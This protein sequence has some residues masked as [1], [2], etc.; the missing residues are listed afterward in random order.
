MPFSQ[1]NLHLLVIEDNPGDF[2]L[3]EEYLREEMKSITIQHATTLKGAR[4]IIS[5]R[6]KID[7]VLLDLSLPDAKGEHL[8]NDVLTL[9]GDTPLIVLTGYADRGFSIKTLSLGVSDYLLK[10]DLTAP[11]LFKSI[12]YSIER[13]R[14]SNEL[15]GSEEKYRSL[16]RSS[17][18]PM[19]VYDPA[20][21]FFLDVNEAACRHYGYSKEEFLAMT[22]KDIRP[23]EDIKRIEKIVQANKG[24]TNYFEEVFLHLKK[25]GEL[26]HANIQSNAITFS[27]KTARLVVS[28]DVTEKI[29]AENALKLSEQR[30]KSLVQDGSD[31]IYILGKDGGY[32]YVSPTSESILGMRPEEFISKNFFDFI[33]ENDRQRI[34]NQFTLL[35]SRKRIHILPFRFKCPNNTYR[36]VETIVTNMMEDPSINGMVANSR[37]VS[38]RYVYEEKLRKQEALFRAIIEKGSDMKTLITPEGKI[39]FGT[40]SITRILGYSEEEY[41]GKNEREIVH[42]DD[43]E[44]LFKRINRSISGEKS[45]GNLELRVRAKSGEYRWCEKTITNLLNDPDVNAIVCDFWDITDK[46]KADLQIKESNDRYDL[47]SKATSDA[48]WDYTFSTNKTYIAGTGYKHLFGYDIVN[49]YTEDLFWEEHLHPEDK[50]EVIEKLR[51]FIADTSLTQCA[52]EYRFMKA[53]GNYAYVNDRLFI[54]RENGIPMRLIGAINDITR[55]KEEEQHLKLLESVI[56]NASDS[57]MITEAV[58]SEKRVPKI[59]YVNEAFTNMSGYSNTEIVGKTP[60]LLLGPRSGRKEILR[61]NK[62]FRNHESCNVEMIN[63][64]KN[65]LPYWVE[66]DVAHVVGITGNVSH[67]IAIQRDITSRKIQEQE[68]EKLIFELIQNNKDLRQFSYITS[69]NLR[70]PIASLLGLTNL[71]DNYR[72]E[73]PVLGKILEGVK[74]A[75]SRFDETITDLTAVLNIKDRPSIPKEELNLK[76]SFEKIMQQ[77]EVFIKENKV[78]V[79]NDF[80]QAPTIHFNKAYLDSILLNLLTNAIKYRSPLRELRIDVSTEQTEEEVLLKFKDNGLGFDMELHKGKLF[81]LYQRFHEHVE[82]KGMGL[83]LVKSQM[84]ALNGNIEVSSDTASGTLFTLKFKKTA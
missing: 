20:T 57:V 48:I 2:V 50:N 84:E 27:G 9:T 82:G 33:H 72:I 13:K 15:K 18:L 55:R 79:K 14:I 54:I 34:I 68:R 52:Y 17:P 51:A 77:Y 61:L 69:H 58:L 75:A 44:E 10:D 19:W 59:I 24:L 64:S 71:I 35:L 38:E 81:G 73:D 4:E 60:D 28:T 56:T 46:K 37:D 41:L 39:I 47:V 83:F 32:K 3:I 42:P 29:K 6:R 65:G 21:Y 22:I 30:F 63:Y 26:I 16:F 74:K 25:N 12:S 66:I 49:D 78:L 31:L 80:T 23:K 8:V 62:A 45:T 36:W 40:P 43:T 76:L 11:Q 67:I 70:G 7:V 1:K 53:D 5:E